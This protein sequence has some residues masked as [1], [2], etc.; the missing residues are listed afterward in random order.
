MAQD[1]NQEIEWQFD[2]DDL[3]RARD[4]I[5]TFVKSLP[6][7]ITIK[8][9]ISQTD[10]YFDTEDLT[11]FK[12]R[13]SLRIRKLKK[14]HEACLKSLVKPEDLSKSD[15]P[16]RKEFTQKVSS[17]EAQQ[18]TNLPGEMG[19]IIQAKHPKSVIGKVLT[20]KTRRERIEIAAGAAPFAE[21]AL[22]KTILVSPNIGSEPFLSRVEIEVL[23]SAFGPTIQN[24]VRRMRKYL[25]QENVTL[26]FA[27][28]SKFVTALTAAQIEVPQKNFGAYSF[29][30]KM[31]L[32]RYVTAVFRKYL[33]N[34]FQNESGCRVGI[35]PEFVHQMRVNLR[36]VI[37]AMKTLKDY[38]PE[39]ITAFRDFLRSVISTLGAVRDLDVQV[40]ALKEDQE[41]ELFGDEKGL[42]ELITLLQKKREDAHNNLLNIFNSKLYAKTLRMLIAT[43]NN[44]KMPSETEIA[45]DVYADLIEAPLRQFQKLGK[46]LTPDAKAKRFHKVRIK[47]KELRYTMEFFLP[48]AEKQIA[49]FIDLM[50]SIQDELGA[51]ND[52]RVGRER[53]TEIAFKKGDQFSPEALFVMGQAAMRYTDEEKENREKFVE[54]FQKIKFERMVKAL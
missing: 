46:K 10:T 24:I 32:D 12:A 19:K 13:F 49:G 26:T 54:G 11:Y 3:K 53:I 45:G 17:M 8:K 6:Y 36:R 38:I 21:I 43:L 52:C 40:A 27:K 44:P 31:P 1:T 30:K 28:Q 35:E 50:S 20:I 34:A 47:G 18:L 39:E 15:P 9:P 2:A 22:D 42:L 29:N 33:H 25:Q 14:T 16:K 7:R 41:E 48:L 23:D 4:L 37:S 5:I 51:I